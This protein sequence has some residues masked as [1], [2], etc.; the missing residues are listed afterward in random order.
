MSR[1]P[2]STSRADALN[3][4]HADE[5]GFSAP[6]AQLH[7][8]ASSFTHGR[9]PRGFSARLHRPSRTDAIFFPRGFLSV[10]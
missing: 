8:A 6:D 7:R 2:D 1:R 10:F 9:D 3:F 4:T 5:L